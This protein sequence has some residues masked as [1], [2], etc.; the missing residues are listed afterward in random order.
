MLP[1]KSFWA[2]QACTI[3]STMIN[4]NFLTPYVTQYSK[5]EPRSVCITF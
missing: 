1:F 5:S 4:D 2:A 3:P